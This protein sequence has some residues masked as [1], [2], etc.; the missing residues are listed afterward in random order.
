MPH[1][2]DSV[3]T[4]R[5]T[6]ELLGVAVSTA[7]LWIENGAIPSWKTP[8][9]HRRVRLSAVRRLMEQRNGDGAPAGAAKPNERAASGVEFLPAAA[10]PYPVAHDEAER[11]LALDAARLVDTPAES[12]FDRLTWLASQVTDSPMALISL[13]TSRRQWFKS[14]VGI[15]ASETPRDWAFCSHAILQKGLFVVEDAT[16]DP[17]F[18]DNPLVTGEPHIRFYAAFPLLDGGN[19]PLGT[20]CI[21]DREPRKLRD[22]EVRSLRELA[23]LAS[24]EI[25]RRA[26]R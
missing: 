24:E 26:P 8:G 22:R 14:R 10:P 20:L 13:L 17:R 3:L 6:A 2:K 19:H 4:T 9:G 12:V 25:Q 1:S 23:A 15:D 7:Q 18:H 5:A 16:R 21:L 11:L